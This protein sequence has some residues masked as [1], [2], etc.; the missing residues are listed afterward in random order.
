LNSNSNEATRDSSSEQKATDDF[1]RQETLRNANIRVRVGI[2]SS[3]LQGPR[4]RYFTFSHCK[5]VSTPRMIR[6]EDLQLNIFQT[7]SVELHLEVNQLALLFPN[8]STENTA[9]VHLE[10]KSNRV[11]INN[12]AGGAL[13]ATRLQ[14]KDLYMENIKEADIRVYASEVARI[15]QVENCKIQ[16]EGNPPYQW[17]E[18]RE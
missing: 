2:G 17:I 7:D 12:F 1:I 4:Y 15:Q 5:K 8:F 10:G 13:D 3:H 11:N 9:S 6:S 16:V 18:G 14:A